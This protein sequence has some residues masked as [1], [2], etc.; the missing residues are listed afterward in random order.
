MAH[1]LRIQTC[2]VINYNFDKQLQQTV[3]VDNNSFTY[4]FMLILRIFK[5]ALFLSKRQ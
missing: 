3:A 2:Y 1:V 5:M 4:V